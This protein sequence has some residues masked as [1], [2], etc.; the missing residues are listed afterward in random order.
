[1]RNSEKCG[2]CTA[3]ALI[4]ADMEE[5]ES[6]EGGSWDGSEWTCEK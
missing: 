6:N 5:E 2:S 3:A 4:R 1:M